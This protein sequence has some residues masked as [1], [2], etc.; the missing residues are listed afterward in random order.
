MGND[1]VRMI[2]L[3]RRLKL[4]RETAL[5]FSCSM[6]CISP[7]TMVRARPG[8][9]GA[10]VCNQRPKRPLLYIRGFGQRCN[11]ILSLEPRM[12]CENPFTLR[13]PLP[14]SFEFPGIFIIIVVVVVVVVDCDL[15]AVM[16][17]AQQH[18]REGGQWIRE[19]TTWNKFITMEY[20]TVYFETFRRNFS[21]PQMRNVVHSWVAG[22]KHLPSDQ[23]DGQHED[24]R[25]TSWLEN[26]PRF[27]L[28]D[29][30]D[31]IY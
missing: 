15:K 23:L 19:I 12:R 4:N 16:I 13:S 22:R 11:I 2:S 14:V 29:E 26:T 18:S 17:C 8:S 25:W 28:V 10:R 5:I 7:G 9:E 24:V 27:D 3:N 30:N 21:F 6:R 31:A 20:V 1:V